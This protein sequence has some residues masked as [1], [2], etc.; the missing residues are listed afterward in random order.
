[1]TSLSY[2]AWKDDKRSFISYNMPDICC[3]I[4]MLMKLIFDDIW[5]YESNECTDK[6]IEKNER[7]SVEL[8]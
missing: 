1:M 6:T 3:A 7:K 2:K 5:L 4:V 8:K